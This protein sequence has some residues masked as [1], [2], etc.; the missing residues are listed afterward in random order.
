MILRKFM[1][2]RFFASLPVAIPVPEQPVPIQHYLRQPQRLVKALVDPTRT[3]QLSQDC[4]R[5]KMRPLNFLM[6]S[7]QPIVDMRVWAEPNGTIRLR[8]NRCEI[9]G[10]EYINQRFSLNLAGK[11]EPRT[12]NGKTILYGRA[13][14]EVKVEIPPA[15]WLTPQPIIDGTGNTLLNSVLH[16]I[17]QRLT[18]HLIADY[19]A[20]A[21]D[22]Q[23]Q[24]TTSATLQLSPN[25]QSS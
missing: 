7:V 20:W 11:L 24:K 8:S 1:Y 9:R 13:D 4:F 2:R 25:A 12:A 6:L 15:L 10:I 14:L 17:K 18:K 5:L 3:E 19:R 21:G 16:T 22:E 23:N